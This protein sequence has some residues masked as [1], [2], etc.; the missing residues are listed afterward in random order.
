MN[1]IYYVLF[2]AVSAVVGAATAYVCNRAE[3][4]RELRKN[5]IGKR[6]RI[7]TR[8]GKI[9]HGWISFKYADGTCIVITDLNGAV[10]AS[11]KNIEPD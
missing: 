3:K 7:K 11:L 5:P 4:M 8:S 2:I 9:M 10:S 6:V 1:L